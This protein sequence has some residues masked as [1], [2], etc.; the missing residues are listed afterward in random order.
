MSPLVQSEL[1]VSESP[2]VDAGPQSAVSDQAEAAIRQ[3]RYSALRNVCCEY[4]EGVLTLR[5][6]VPTYFLKQIA[7]SL[8]AAIPGVEAIHNRTKVGKETHRPHGPLVD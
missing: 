5:G 2:F 8:V 6:A 3:S 4:H 1:K 7:Q